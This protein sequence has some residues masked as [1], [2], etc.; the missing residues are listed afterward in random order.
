MKLSFR[1]SVIVLCLFCLQGLSIS[2]SAKAQ[3]YLEDDAARK[4]LDE[5]GMLPQIADDMAASQASTYA[6]IGNLV[7][8][9]RAEN[10]NFGVSV[11]LD[12]TTLFV[13][14]SGADVDGARNQGAVYV[15][16]REGES[17][18]Q[19]QKL[20]ASD[21][22]TDDQFGSAIALDGGTVLIG[23][24]KADVNGNRDQG[25]VYVFAHSQNGWNQQQKLVADDGTEEDHFGVS[26]ALDGETALIGA[27]MVDIDDVSGVGAAYIFEREETIWSQQQK[28]IADNYLRSRNFGVAVALDGETAL[29]GAHNAL[30]D[31]PESGGGAAY[32][33]VR[34]GTIWD[35]QQ[36]LVA[37]KGQTN[38]R[39]GISVALDGETALI[40][41]DGTGSA[42]AA[43][44]FVRGETTWRQQQKLIPVDDMDVGRFGD[45]VALV[46]E[47][48]HIGARASYG[49]G[50]TYV[51]AF[52]GGNWD[53]QQRLFAGPDGRAGSFGTSIA[54]G[55]SYLLIGA[56]STDVDDI[57]QSGRV[58]LFELRP[59][60]WTQ[61][62][63]VVADDG[64]E[65][66]LF[67]Y[68]LDLNNNT[69]I[70]GAYEANVN[71]ND[72]QGAAYIFMRNGSAWMQQQKL[73][74]SDGVPNDRFGI[75]VALDGETALVGAYQ[76]EASGV[77]SGAA[78]VFMREGA[79]WGQQQKL[80]PDD[81]D[82]GDR[83]GLTVALDGETAL[84][85]ADFLFVDEKQEQV[86]A[87][88]FQR[89]GTSWS[90]Q[91]ELVIRD[92]TTR[93]T[94]SVSVALD[95]NTALV[96]SYP[97][98]SFMN[99]KIG[100]VHI[101][102]R[103]ETSWNLQQILTASDDGSR[104]SFGRTLAVNGD[105]ALIS[106]S[107]SVDVFVR[108]G[109]S[110]SQQQ[111][112]TASDGVPFGSSV[113]LDGEIAVVGAAGADANGIRNQ[114]AAYIF[115]REGDRWSQQQKIS[116]D[117]D[118]SGDSFGRSVALSGETMFIGA[119]ETDVN[120]NR[121]QGNAYFFERERV[122]Q[123]IDF[124]APVN[125]DQGYPVGT[126]V[127]LS[128]TASSGLPVDIQSRTPAV[129][130]VADG[131]ATTVA[132][133]NCCLA[134]SQPGDATYLAAPD[135][136]ISF[137]VLAAMPAPTSMPMQSAAES[138]FLPLVSQQTCR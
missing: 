105:T 117:G 43:Y 15:F 103:Q 86:A 33:F 24:Q 104:K 40:G 129:C 72:Q 78:Y 128:A 66:E 122:T 56:P 84:I 133:G 118:S 54:I 19:Q 29:I 101:F 99:D 74:A 98:D 35:Q 108:E 9:D 97:A 138:I 38:G 102:V 81:R 57:E 67:G 59:I 116:V 65:S 1:L 34:E 53:Q 76:A 48:A 2:T 60:F 55:G 26:V 135:A 90:Q 136:A 39:F 42:G 110:W 91:Q 79:S 22:A 113:A 64:A 111:K 137:Q 85:G 112:L 75:S 58:H 13:G 126:T 27:D 83:F 12:S 96:G 73:S 3:V 131:N 62:I 44:I 115:V 21:G 100:T 8:E 16:V 5:H 87:Y 61:A 45:S 28:L 70:V 125:A 106:A 134:A 109:T 32:I 93:G 63:S 17:W 51:F 36:K 120:E 82:R 94:V 11:A 92:T 127:P 46:G 80:A 124:A 50:A 49:Q 68:T 88:I 31:I 71:G 41:A 30:T 89:E 37:D 52:D 114:G 4:F 47:V 95:G 107:G 132:P 130:T 6:E 69:A 123:I 10:D 77:S 23:A 14:A 25:A 119:S 7:A 121:R 20:V 18:N